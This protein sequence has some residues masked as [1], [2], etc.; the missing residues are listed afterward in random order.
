MQK[1]WASQ[2][3]R[4]FRLDYQNWM[5]ALHFRHLMV[6]RYP[7]ILVVTFPQGHSTWAMIR[8]EIASTRTFPTTLRPHSQK[9]PYVRSDK[10]GLAIWASFFP[11]FGQ[12]HSYIISDQESGIGDQ[13]LK[14]LEGNINGG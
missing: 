2:E 7:K 1:A 14:N 4:S 8:F 11:S 6:T 12:R 10:G 3:P 13:W 9:C 5:I